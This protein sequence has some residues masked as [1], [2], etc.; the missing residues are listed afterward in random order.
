[1]EI[2]EIKQS[3]EQIKLNKKKKA[4][5]I[6]VLIVLGLAF[7]AFGVHS[8]ITSDRVEMPDLV[9][10]NVITAQRIIKNAGL[11][12]EAVNYDPESECEEGE[13]IA[14]RPQEGN[15]LQKGNQVVLTVAGKERPN[16][17]D[18]QTG[19]NGPAD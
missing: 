18:E 15:I 10:L 4:T 17:D 2:E 12:L 6:V 5:Q 19:S 13:V 14:Q 16:S 3:P 7:F 1:M 11:K 9:G 8:A